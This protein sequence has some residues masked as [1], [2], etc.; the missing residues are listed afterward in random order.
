MLKCSVR[1]VSIWRITAVTVVFLVATGCGSSSRYAPVSGTVRLNGQPYKDAVVTFQ[2]MATSTNSNPGRGS[3]AYTDES[4]RFVLRTDDGDNG[5]AI[6]KHRIRIATKVGGRMAYDPE[7]GS[8][9]SGPA[10]PKLSSDPI[11]RSWNAE[12]DKEFDVPPGGTD[13]A[14]FEIVGKS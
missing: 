6:G 2:P 11:P 13:Q 4:G 12:S 8:P 3:S 7:K 14:N 10:G 1:C 9:D 5:A